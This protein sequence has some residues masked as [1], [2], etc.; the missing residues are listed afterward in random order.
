MITNYHVEKMTPEMLY[1]NYL[2]ASY[3]YYQL[4]ETIMLDTTF[5]YLVQKLIPHF[6][7]LNHKDKHLTTMEDLNAST[8]LLLRNNYPSEVKI[9]ALKYLE[10]AEKGLI[11]IKDMKGGYD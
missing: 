3:C 9:N 8:C 5:D 4:D 2:M 6:E 7:P 11:P 10:Q 1:Q